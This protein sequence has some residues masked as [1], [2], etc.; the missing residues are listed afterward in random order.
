MR[1]P[2]NGGLLLRLPKLSIRL[3]FL[4]TVPILHLPPSAIMKASIVTALLGASVV[5]AKVHKAKLNKVPIAEQLVRASPLL[6]PYSLG[7]SVYE[8]VLTPPAGEL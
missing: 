3:S 6:L 7:S 5:T 4:H 1:R 2:G 8:A